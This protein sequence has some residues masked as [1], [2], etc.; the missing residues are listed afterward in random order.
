MLISSLIFLF[1]EIE[2]LFVFNAECKLRNKKP[3]VI[4]FQRPNSNYPPCINNVVVNIS[5]VK[6]FPNVNKALFKHSH[7]NPL[8]IFC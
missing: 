4:N 3:L 5:H 1:I 6:Y 7:R 2:T 8:S